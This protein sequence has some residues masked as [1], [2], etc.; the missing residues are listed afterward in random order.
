MKKTNIIRKTVGVDAGMIWIGDPCYIM[1]EDTSHRPESWDGF[2]HDIEELNNVAE[3]LG[4][5]IGCAIS[6]GFGDGAYDVEIETTDCGSWGER[7]SKVTVTFFDPNELDEDYDDEFG[8]FDDPYYQD[9][10]VGVSQ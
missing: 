3:P 8:M 6:S 2:C 1:G 9:P 4:K 10:E 7:V 5:G